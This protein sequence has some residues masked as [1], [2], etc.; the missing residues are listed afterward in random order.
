MSHA[1]AAEAPGS[2]LRD[3]SRPIL[4]LT[5]F[6]EDAQ[7]GGAVILRSLLLG[8]SERSGIVW[9]SP[10]PPSGS[11]RDGSVTLAKGSAGRGRR[12]MFADS[13]FHA[14]AL[15]E[16][17]R[18]IARQRSARGLWIIMHGAAVHIAAK[19]VRDGSLPVHL[20]VHDDPAYANALRSKR[21]LALMP[22]IARDL[23]R[24]LRGAASVDVIGEGMADRYRRMYGVE[25]TIV[26]RGLDQAVE[27]SPGYDRARLGLRV[28]I[29]GNTYNY[30]QLTV[31][32]RAVA[33]AASRSG[34]RGGVVVMGRSYGDR[35]KAEMGGQV[36]VEITGHLGEAQGIE[37]LRECFALYLNYPFGR[38]DAVLRQTSFPTK[39]STY[40]MAARPLLMHVPPDSSVMPLATD[41]P[42]YAVPW[43]NL[44]AGDGA[45]ILERMWDAPGSAASAH[46]AAERTRRRYYDL[47]HNRRV[48]FAALDALAARPS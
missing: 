22:W 26:H 28:G 23:G 13:V 40:V 44:D 18:E 46:E 27:P 14:G 6:P 42:G 31:L 36:D 47:D 45:A 48:L 12:S 29:L 1:A 8:E 32:G 38:R 24:A 34:T 11:P 21:Y 25:S 30:E 19:L 9:A 7:G 5:D 10:T 2:G 16:E 3:P 4:L 35:L 15:A 20:T 39:L 33:Q 37:R 43:A 17:V 41:E